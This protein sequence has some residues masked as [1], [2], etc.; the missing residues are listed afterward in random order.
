MDTTTIARKIEA[1]LFV[2][3]EPLSYARLRDIVQV[4][5]NQ[6]E[7][8]LQELSARLSHGIRLVRAEKVVG[9]ATAPEEAEYVTV[10]LKD[11]GEKDIGQAG[12]EVLAIILY[13]GSC[14]KAS[15]DYIRGVNSSST[16][17]TLLYRG[18]IERIVSG[19]EVTYVPTAELL[20][21]LGSSDRT[22][23]PEFER[24]SKELAAYKARSAEDATTEA[25]TPAA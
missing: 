2:A 8:G 5:A 22:S 12:L 4:D 11:P 19:R 16:I 14:S 17:R 1:L 25:A 9:L 7:A 10:L 13:E 3:G 24:L 21:H 15:I 6:L 23:L 20:A 18:L